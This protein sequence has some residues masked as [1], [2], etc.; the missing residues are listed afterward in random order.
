MGGESMA[1]FQCKCGE[2]LSNSMAP[3]DVQLKVFT[4][5]EWDDIINVGMI[6]SVD[7]PDPKYDIW[8][9]QK[10]ERIYVFGH[11]S[12]NVIKTYALEL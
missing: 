12:N 3:N 2:T 8:R 5:R 10:C 4:D 9:C 11:N 1:R 7:L 6:D